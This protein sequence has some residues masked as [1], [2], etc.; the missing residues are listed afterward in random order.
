[1]LLLGFEHLQKPKKLINLK[2]IKIIE[3]KKK[4]TIS[5]SAARSGFLTSE[6]IDLCLVDS[7]VLGFMSRGF[8]NNIQGTHAAAT[9][10]LFKNMKFEKSLKNQKIPKILKIYSKV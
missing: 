9:T 6:E 3:I 8:T 2:N 7:G 4:I 10:F 1:M 5:I